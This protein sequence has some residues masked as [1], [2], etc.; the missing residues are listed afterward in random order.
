MKPTY[1]DIYYAVLYANGIAD[2][3]PKCFNDHY[4]GYFNL[5]IKKL[6]FFLNPYYHEVHILF[7]QL[8]IK[9]ILSAGLKISLITIKDEI[10]EIYQ[11]LKELGTT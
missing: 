6:Y 3:S 1:S 7:Y 11:T 2:T 10:H 9:I 8:F 5:Q 4:I